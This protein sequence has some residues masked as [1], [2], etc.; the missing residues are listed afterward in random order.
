MASLFGGNDAVCYPLHALGICNG[1]AAKLLND[2]THG[3]SLKH[4]QH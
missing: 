3:L 4:T 1:G 2:K